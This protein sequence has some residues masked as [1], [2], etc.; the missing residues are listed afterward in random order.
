CEPCPMCL[1]AIYW[2]RISNIYY[3]NTREDAA[4][5]DFDDEFL[6]EEIKKSVDQRKIP[7]KQLLRD[8]ANI[9]FKEW[10]NKEDKIHY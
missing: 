7:M 8:E 4:A 5:L 3:A 6:Y 9:V 1:S 10:Q 2:A